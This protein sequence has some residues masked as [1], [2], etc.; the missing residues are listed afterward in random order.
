MTREETLIRYRHLRGINT[1][2]QNNSL[3]FI[4]RN[5]MLDYGRRLGLLHGRTL[6]CEETEMP[7]LFDLAVHTAREGRT[8]AIDRYARS[9]QLAEGSD[10][11]MMLKAAQQARFCVW[12][13]E[14]LRQPAGLSVRDFIGERDLWLLDEGMESCDPIGAVIAGRLMAVEDFVMTCGVIVPLNKD[15][16]NE[17]LESAPNL[18]DRDLA[19]TLQHPR[20]A[21]AIYRAAITTGVVSSVEYVGLDDERPAEPR[22]A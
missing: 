18:G 6:V 17:A 3:K 2:Q 22:A 13:V 1:Q 16:L 11:A 10:E 14:G 19:A 5:T 9:V 12:R 4:S 8:R 21:V 7:F 15:V 20:F